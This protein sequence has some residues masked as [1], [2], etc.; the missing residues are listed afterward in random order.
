VHILFITRNPFEDR[1]ILFE[2]TLKVNFKQKVKNSSNIL[3]GP[4]DVKIYR[5]FNRTNNEYA[6]VSLHA[7]FNLSQHLKETNAFYDSETIRIDIQVRELIS[8]L[9]T[10]QW[11]NLKIRNL[12]SN[13]KQKKELRFVVNVLC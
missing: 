4:K 10:K 5:L 2:L 11:M 12:F 9:F 3:L 7:T 6:L 13:N 1:E 8:N